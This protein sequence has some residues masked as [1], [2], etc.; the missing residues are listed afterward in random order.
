MIAALEVAVTK[1]EDIGSNKMDKVWLKSYPPGVPAEIDVNRY[2][3]LTS[4]LEEVFSKYAKQAAFTCM[5]ATLSFAE[6]EKYSRYCAAWFQ[7]QGVKTGT[8]VALMMPNILQ[9]PICIAGILRA[10]GVLV[11]V[12]PLSV[13]RELE[14]QLVDSGAEIIVVMEN[15]ANVLE[16]VIARTQIKHVVVTG[17]G[18]MLGHL[19]GGMV[20]LVI[21]HIKK[22]VPAWHISNAI[23]F[24]SMLKQGASQ[25]L[26]PI[27]LGHQD[28]AV[29]QYTGGTTG[30]PKG[31]VLTHQNLIANILQADAW[32]QPALHHNGVAIQSVV[33]IS[34][35]PLYHIFGLTV[36]YFLGMRIGA[37]NVLIPNPRDIKGLIKTLKAHQFHLLPAVNT[38]Y[39]ALLNHPEIRTV[40]FSNLKV[41][42]G[43]GMAVQEAVAQKWLAVTGCPIIEGYGLSEASPCVTCNPT[44]NHVFTGTIGLPFPSTEVVIRDEEGH[45]L[46]FGEMGEICIRGPQ[47]MRGYW[48]RP[49]ETAKVFSQDGF[50]KT[51]DLGFINE[52]GYIKL[53]ERKK[54]VIIVSGFNVYPN[55]VEDVLALMP[56]VLEVAAIG[57]PDSH[58]GEVVKVFIVKQEAGLSEAEVIAYCR[59]NLAS[60]KCPKHIKFC[61]SLPKTTVGKILRRALREME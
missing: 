15:F 31:A 30:V 10:G 28:I 57:V 6:V 42:L 21:R 39:N 14:H 26:Q 17:L 53:V 41:A 51:G 40:D 44:D 49:E 36:C 38:L 1:F 20:N 12:N 7:S 32:T 27:S 33:S 4:L 46:S 8:R 23:R 11:N 25:A 13:A 22:M 60:Y 5:G 18:D 47:V 54:D 2:A 9:Y 19:K 35:L 55:E 34:A 45:D 52:Q 56:G 29:L 43:G 61:D 37:L 24:K 16:Q 48:Q 58:S 59:K 50:L 3:S